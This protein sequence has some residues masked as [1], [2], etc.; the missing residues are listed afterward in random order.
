MF[1]IVHLLLICSFPHIEACDS[2]F[3]IVLHEETG[4]QSKIVASHSSKVVVLEQSSGFVV[5]P[6]E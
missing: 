2:R 3:F 1:L 5:H 4:N 6:A